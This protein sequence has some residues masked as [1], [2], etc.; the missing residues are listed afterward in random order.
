[1]GSVPVSV[2]EKVARANRAGTSGDLRSR[3]HGRNR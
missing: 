1:M 2:L 3:S